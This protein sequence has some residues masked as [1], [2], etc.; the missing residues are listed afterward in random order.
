MNLE[1]IRCS[2]DVYKFMED[3]I[4]YGWI[5]VN[6]NKHLNTM[7]EFRTMYRTMSIDEILKFKIQNFLRL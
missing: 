6:G 1:E 3:N 4:N 2:K 7:K 5:D